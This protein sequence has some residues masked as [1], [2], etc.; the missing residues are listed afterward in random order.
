MDSRTRGLA[1]SRTHGLT[2]SWTHGLMDSRTHGL[3]D[4]QTCGLVP[5]IFTAGILCRHTATCES[6]NLWVRR[7]VYIRPNRWASLYLDLHRMSLRP[8]L[9]LR[10]GFGY[11]DGIKIVR[12]HS[13]APTGWF[14]G[15]YAPLRPPLVP[16]LR[17]ITNI[18]IAHTGRSSRYFSPHAFLY[19]TQCTATK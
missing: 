11:S 12:E 15:A 17:T 9:D 16:P 8:S 18:S 4:S 13:M 7:I 10:Y 3:T 1:D 19:V 14:G 6:A 5:E 2:D